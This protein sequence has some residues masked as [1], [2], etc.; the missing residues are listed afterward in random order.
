MHLGIQVFICACIHIHMHTHIPYIHTHV[1]VPKGA[2]TPAATQRK[3]YDDTHARI[4]KSTHNTH[5]YI[6][7]HAHTSTSISR[8]GQTASQH[9][10]YDDTYVC[11]IHFHTHMCV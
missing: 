5:T 8:K 1:H 6:Y 9:I 3:G 4:F 11:V 7:S 10:G 2:C